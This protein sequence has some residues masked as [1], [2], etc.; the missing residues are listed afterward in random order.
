MMML[1]EDKR[2]KT[3][4]IVEKWLQTIPKANLMQRITNMDWSN[5]STNYEQFVSSC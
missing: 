1:P 4:S 5:I 2:T 3:R